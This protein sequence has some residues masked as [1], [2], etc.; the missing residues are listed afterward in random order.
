MTESAITTTHPERETMGYQ[1]IENL[2][3]PYA[4]A[5]LLFRECYA[6][7]KIHGTSAHISWQEGALAF[8]SGGEKHS[9]FVALFDEAA[10]RA[11]FEALGHNYVT[12]FGEAYGGSQQKQ[13][14]RYGE[15]LRFVAFEVVID[16]TWL[17]V[18]NAHDVCGKLGLEFV[19]YTRISTDLAAIDAERDAPSEQ[20]KRNGV[21][22]P[23][24]REG[25]VLRP[26]IEVVRSDGRRIMAKHKRDEERETATPRQVVD[27]SQ[28]QVL[29]D[30]EKIALEWVTDT[31]LA[32][33]LDK[34]PG[35]HG[36]PQMT[37]VIQ[38]MTEDVLREGSGEIVDSK[39][40]RQAIAKRTA[41]L[42]KNHVRTINA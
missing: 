5:I 29:A 37:V 1:H 30:A 20:A 36:L 6:L 17:D 12:V 22:T 40:A 19:H 32:H 11:A 39:Q 14:H 4:Q 9:R 38:A 34:I 42:F 28:M 21:P 41:V 8:F 26:L 18:P 15:Q 24:P 10:L 31:R 3:R 16:S 7:E 13:A 27:P 35:P 25:V 33:V 2:Y 23:Q